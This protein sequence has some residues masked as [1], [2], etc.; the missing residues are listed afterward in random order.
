MENKIPKII[1]YCWLSNDP[2]PVFIEEC[3]ATWSVIMPDYEIICWDS[4]RFPINEVPFV[5]AAYQARKWAFAADYIRLYAL[6]HHGGIYLDS[7]V[8]VYKPFDRFLSHAAFSG[9]EF[10]PEMF[11]QSIKKNS[12]AGLGIEAAVIGSAPQ[13]PW[14]K[15]C[16]DFY[17]QKTFINSPEFM[18]SM[19]MSGILPE[20]LIPFGFKYEPL[21]QQL[22]QDIHIYP[23]DVFSNRNQPSFLKYS[24]H[25]CA[26]SWREG[27]QPSVWEQ[28]VF[29][30]KKFVLEKVIGKDNYAKIKKRT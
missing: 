22:D 17:Q 18:D 21:Y 4:Q 9:V 14:I 2:K 27:K 12:Y 20:L 15:S 26:N 28:T 10:H 8:K 29:K 1:H 11:Y 3:M 5:K 24:S 7:D 13:H 23:P 25:L 16:L 30:C 6:Y 19:I